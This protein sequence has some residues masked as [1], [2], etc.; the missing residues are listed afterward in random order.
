MQDFV[1][2]YIK[3]QEAALAAKCT[4][5][6]A[7]GSVAEAE[8]RE[9]DARLIRLGMCEKQYNPE[10]TYSA[11][12]PY[13]EYKSGKYYR[14]V[15]FAVSDEEYA[16]ICRYDNSPIKLKPE[17]FTDRVLGKSYKGMRRIAMFSLIFGV[18]VS[19]LGGVLLYFADSQYLLV[20]VLIAVLGSVFSWLS[21]VHFFAVSKTL[22]RV[23]YLLA[24]YE[25]KKD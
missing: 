23:E 19:I 22:D 21:T 3:E 24:R 25:Q 4:S 9:R 2:K 20:S 12:Y 11:D 14:F 6:D 18:L 16:A 1:E 13:Q 5:V 7:S 10:T 15:P 8:A 17:S